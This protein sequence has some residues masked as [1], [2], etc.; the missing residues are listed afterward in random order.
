MVASC[1][2]GRW[3]AALA[4]IGL[5]LP[6]AP[7]AAKEIVP[8]KAPIIRDVEL[9]VGGLLVGRLLDANGRP[10]D[11]ADI[12]IQSGSKTLASTRTDAE[13]VFAVSNLRGGVHQIT[14]ADNVQL[15]RLWAHGTA[16][17]RTAKSIDV[18]SGSDVVRGQYG[19]P[20]GNRMWKK[21]KVWA[22]NPWIVGG[23]VAAAVAIPVALSDN[24]GPHS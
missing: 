11:N 6:I 17:P 20:P 21:A 23:V 22:T 18:V 16:P 24:D 7:A 4:S 14:T 3:L 13:G 9:A 15:C 10:L 5:C 12:S 2:W 1:K 19:P 8:A